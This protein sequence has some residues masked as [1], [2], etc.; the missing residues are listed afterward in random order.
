MTNNWLIYPLAN[1]NRPPKRPEKFPDPPSWRDFEGEPITLPFDD[2]THLTPTNE[3]EPPK[4]SGWR[5]SDWLRGKTFQADEDVVKVVN[6]ALYLRRPI[7]ITGK[8]G[9]GKSSLAYAV[10][11]QLQLGPVLRWSI[12]SRSTLQEGLYSYDA[13]GRLQEVSLRER[14][15]HHLSHT[16]LP[17]VEGQ[18]QEEQNEMVKKHVDERLSKLEQEIGK[19][20]RLGPLGTALLPNK[21][22]PRV[23]LIDEIDKSD[24]DLP[25]DLLNI[26]EE[27]EFEI[28]ELA[29]L[30]Q[31]EVMVRLYD[32]FPGGQD[33]SVPV[34]HG[35]IQCHQ[36]PLIIL[37]SNAERELPQAFLRRCLS[38]HMEK[39]DKKKL[40]DIV[41]ARFGIEGEIIEGQKDI[42]DQFLARRDK[43]TLANDQLL[44]AL[45]LLKQD[46]DLYTRLDTE[47]KKRKDQL[48]DIILEYLDRIRV[49]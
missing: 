43:G 26:F 19:Y 42:I 28:P 4:N 8:P 22:Y 45:Y 35:R 11:Y 49:S 24:L 37:T 1:E 6:A 2:P 20:I 3:N 48:I 5:K 18:S 9:I 30:S 13:I 46:V 38:L 7:L 40:E 12:T 23:L 39:P 31:P 10:A 29:R 15:A 21:D 25:N 17:F 27:G 34:Q 16:S 32:R 33:V 36:F 14:I 41:K 47:Q 44:N